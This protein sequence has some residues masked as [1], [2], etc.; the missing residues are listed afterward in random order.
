MD[1]IPFVAPTRNLSK[2]GLSFLHGGFVYPGTRCMVQLITTLGA[3]DDVL[4]TVVSCRYIESMIHE[5][6]IRFDREIDPSVYGT[7]ASCKHD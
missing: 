3:S 1:A 7:S 2:G 5:V 4:G 6:S